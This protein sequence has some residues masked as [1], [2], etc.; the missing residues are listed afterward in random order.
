MPRI[1]TGTIIKLVIACLA[2]GMV[3]AA[4]DVDPR[5]ILSSGKDAIE[6][7]IQRGGEFFGWAVTYILLGAVVVIP[8]WLIMYLLKAARG[9]N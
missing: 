3:L 4:L 2:V 5:N 9:R 7:L 6:W 1:T 8:I